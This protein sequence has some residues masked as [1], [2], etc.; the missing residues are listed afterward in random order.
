[1]TNQSSS[2]QTSTAT[3][4]EEGEG[5][6][7]VGQVVLLSQKRR[8]QNHRDSIA[9]LPAGMVFTPPSVGFS[10]FGKED[11]FTTIT[12]MRDKSMPNV[13]HGRL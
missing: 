10:M 5:G 12:T 13:H 2:G 9:S 1:M 11:G 8:L 6:V 4:E 3:A 7:G